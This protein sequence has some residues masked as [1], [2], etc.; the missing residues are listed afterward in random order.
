[1]R[2]SEKLPKLRKDNNL[3]QEQLADK[4]GVSRQAVSKWEA[5]NS[6]P[7]MEKMLQMCK[8]LNCHLEDIMDDG[9]IGTENKAQAKNKID[10]NAY[11]KDFLDFITRTYNMFCSMKFG[12]KIKCI[13]EMAVIAIILLIVSTI[14]HSILRYIIYGLIPVQAFWNILSI[15]IKTILIVIS[16]IIFLHLFKIRYLDYFVTVEDQNATEK[17]VEEPIAKKEDKHYQEKKKETIIIRDPKHSTL[18]LFDVLGKILTTM[19]R[20]LAIFAIIPV[21]I[22]FVITTGFA[23]ASIFF[24]KYGILFLFTTIAIIG[25]GLL[26]YD[27]I[28]LLYNFIID[29]EEHFKK[30]FVIGIIGLI[31]CGAGAGFAVCTYLSYPVV[32]KFQDTKYL[33]KTQDIEMKDNLYISKNYKCNYNID[34]S[35]NNLHIEIKHV[36]GT[37]VGFDCYDNYNGYTYCYFYYSMNTLEQFKFI[38]ED[39]KEKRIRDYNNFAKIDITITTSQENYNKL[40]EN[41]NK[42]TNCVK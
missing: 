14:V 30:M 28:E 7:D 20:I 12:E 26:I 9:S 29:K 15:L 22:S 5:G 34:N 41:Y 24:L 18:K 17:T 39:L 25:G 37:N 42:A 1:M 23:A 38:I 36:K 8:I 4:L 33:T 19:I 2:F 13:F 10:F 35:I 27:L 3:S 6:Y 40:Q 11:M 31:M 21:I 16:A 32:D